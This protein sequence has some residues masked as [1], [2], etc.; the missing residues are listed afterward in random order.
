M[1]KLVEKYCI[2]SYCFLIKYFIH[3]CSLFISLILINSPQTT[4][5]IEMLKRAE[6]IE[7]DCYS[8]RTIGTSFRRSIFSDLYHYS[9][10]F[11]AQP[12]ALEKIEFRS[13]SPESRPNMDKIM[14]ATS[15]HKLIF[16]KDISQKISKMQ[17]ECSGAYYK[18]FYGSSYVPPWG[19]ERR[20][21]IIL[22]EPFYIRGIPE[23]HPEDAEV[24]EYVTKSFILQD[25]LIE[26]ENKLKT[27]R[28]IGVA[29][30]VV[31][32]PIIVVY[33]GIYINKS[34]QLIRKRYGN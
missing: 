15:E 12:V 34:L 30:I 17:Y 18:K 1:N 27:P 9:S 32:V 14:K 19:P 16:E 33:L 28:M 26:M 11:Y 25:E 24:E 21:Y 10:D 31:Y 4:T 7:V 2:I 3:I 8:Q 23:Y 5:E 6:L 13:I 22:T 29:I 20:T